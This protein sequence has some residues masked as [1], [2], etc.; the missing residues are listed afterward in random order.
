M[1]HQTPH[2]LKA[3]KDNYIWVIRHPSLDEFLIVDPGDAR[4][5]IDFA[6]QY[7]LTLSTILLTHDHLDHIGGVEDLKSYFLNLNIYGADNF[8]EYN[9][10]IN[11]AE[12]NFKVIS[13]PGHTKKDICFYESKKKWL[14][15]GDTLFSAGCGRVFDGTYAELFTAIQSLYGLPDETKVFCAH[16]YTLKKLKFAHYLEPSNQLIIDYIRELECKPNKIS[17]PS[18]IAFEKKLIHFLS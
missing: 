7:N 13:T 9:K 17:L 3:F 18:T 1:K 14:F 4:P 8:N 5:V 6:K 2:P 11:F 10:N 16:E 12:Y 15:C